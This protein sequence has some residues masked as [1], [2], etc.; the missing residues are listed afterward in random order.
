MKCVNEGD[1]IVGRKLFFQGKNINV[2]KVYQKSG[3]HRGQ[4]ANLYNG[5]C[6]I[7][8]SISLSKKKKK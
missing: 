7:E 1:S 5:E 4:R 3:G 2:L 6:W 8:E